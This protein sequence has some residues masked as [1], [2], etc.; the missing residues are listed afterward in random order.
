M[1]TFLKR[2]IIS[3]LIF[4]CISTGNAQELAGQK[5]P[6]NRIVKIGKIYITGHRKTKTSIIRR[7]LDF[8]EGQEI[9]LQTLKEIL[10]KDHQKLINTRLFLSVEITPLVMSDT[11]IDILIKLRERWYIF[12]IPIFKLA[13]R[14]FTEWWVNQKR[15]FSRVNYG[16]QLF[17]FNLTGRNDKLATTAQFGFTN[18]YQLLYQIPYINQAQ[19]LGMTVATSFS[20][21]KNVSYNT[22]GHRQLFI[23]SDGVIRK[24]YYAG[25]TFSYRPS[26]YSTHRFSLGYNRTSIGDTVRTLNSEYLNNSTP[27]QRYFELSYS[28]IRDKRDY[29]AYPLKGNIYGF[30][31]TKSGLGLFS[32]LDMLTVKASVGVFHPLGEKFY[33]ANRTTAFYNFSDKVP[34]F[35]RVG[36][37]YKPDFIR[38]YERNVIESNRFISNRSSFKFKV[39]SG[40]KQLYKGKGMQQF[41]EFPYAFY[42]KTFLDLGYAGEPLTSTEGNFL[43]KELLVGFGIGLDFVTFY[44]FVIRFEYSINREGQSGFFVNFRSAL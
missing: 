5:V 21:N 2:T 33:W 10:E 34:Y 31:I 6:D 36:F 29:F 43:N 1:P 40:S 14:N 8:Y 38:G 19:T 39:L 24:R 7:E 32:E 42:L 27:L 16:I 11:D 15:D 20:N 28:Y 25:A 4:L 41:Q 17:H 37:G 35:E 44:D 18:R 22:V 26:F 9:G 3:A 13:D 12:P 30:E 23:K